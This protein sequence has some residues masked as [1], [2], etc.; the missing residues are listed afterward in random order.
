[1]TIEPTETG[2]KLLRLIERWGGDLAPDAEDLIGCQGAAFDAVIGALLYRGFIQHGA[3][4][5]FI[6]TDLGKQAISR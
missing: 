2:L 3:W 1:M 6:L 5:T 4:G